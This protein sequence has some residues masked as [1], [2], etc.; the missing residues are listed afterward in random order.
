MSDKNLPIKLVLQKASDTKRN[1][2]GGKVKYFGEVNSKLQEEM[3]GK[4]DH[5]LNF[6]NDVFTENE[7]IPAVGKIVMKQEA[8]A[9][10]HKPSD[11]CRELPIIGGEDLD[12][13]YI[14]VTKKNINKTI[15]LIRNPPSQKFSA[16][17]TAVLDIKPITVEDKISNELVQ[18]SQ[19]GSLTALKAK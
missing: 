7:H 3:I 16:N 2:G 15:D 8:I 6:Y 12:E 5:V 1:L 19:Q 10:S 13:I 14:K 11:F 9:K 18:L 17:L 4:F